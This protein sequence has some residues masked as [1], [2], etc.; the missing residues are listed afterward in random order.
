[1][2]YSS[3][4]YEDIIHLSRPP[5]SHPKM[6][7]E[8]RAAQFAPFAALSGH[9]E[10]VEEKERVTEPKRTL[11][12]DEKYRLDETLQMALTQKEPCL[13]VVYYVPDTHKAGGKYCE[14]KAHL[15]KIDPNLHL[16]IF[17]SGEKIKI[18]DVLRL[19]IIEEV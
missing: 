14:L 12:E 2:K 1:M 15:K 17:K 11:T 13:R 6:S 8:A 7:R 18:N 4:P 10:M 9:K 19:E 16:L 3:S 5:S